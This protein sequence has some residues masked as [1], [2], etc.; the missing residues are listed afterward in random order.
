MRNR[1]L[2]VTLSIFSLMPLALRAQPAPADAVVAVADTRLRLRE[3]PSLE[4]ETLAYLDTETPLTIIGRTADS[5]WLQVYAPEGQSGWVSA[6]FLLVNVELGQVVVVN[7]DELPHPVVLPSAVAET[8]H[9]IYADGQAKGKRAGVFS[10]VG[11]SITAARHFS[12]P[13]GDG[14]YTLADYQYLQGVIDAFTVQTVRDDYNSFTNLSLAAGVGWTTDAVFKSRFADSSVCLHDE[15]PVDCEYRVVQPSVA[16]IMFGSNDVAH[17][18][19]DTYAYNIAR[20]VKLSIEQGVIPI[21][22]TFPARVGYE[23]QSAAF[24]A[25]VVKV[26]QRYHVPLW[27]YDGAMAALPDYGLAPDG[28]HPSIPPA[29]YKGAANFR[30]SNLYYGYVVRNL[31]ALQMLDAVWQ[32]MSEQ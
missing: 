10:K 18:T 19:E 25:R 3:L 23:E 26:A 4:S 1:I 22:S 29:G 16:F 17:L 27:D 8:V 28:V 13:V 21:I 2:F 15:S 24:N 20:L 14:L 5:T 12:N 32:A 31:T 30:P 11:D 7:V 9:Q 6:A